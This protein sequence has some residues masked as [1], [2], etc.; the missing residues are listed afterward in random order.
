M[1]AVRSVDAAMP[2]LM[3]SDAAS[4]LFI[5]TTAA[6]E[7]FMGPTSYNAIKAALITHANGL[8]QTFAK[9]GVRVNTL[10]PGPIF[11]EGGAYD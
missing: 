3:K 9:Q 6:V 1:G 8:S 4:V 11:I 2:S 7:T 5:G 10:S